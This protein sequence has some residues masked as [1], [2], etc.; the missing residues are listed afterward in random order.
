VSHR[1]L[2]ALLATGLFAPGGESMATAVPTDIPGKLQST[3]SDFASTNG[4]SA[5]ELQSLLGTIVLNDTKLAKAGVGLVYGDVYVLLRESRN[6]LSVS[7]KN[8]NG[9]DRRESEV[10]FTDGKS[11]RATPF[12]PGSAHI[13]MVLFMPEEVRYIDLSECVGGRYDRPK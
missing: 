8:W 11:V 10:V 12:P 1:L 7:G 13:V 9:R 6:A 2:I 3:L 4:L 5:T